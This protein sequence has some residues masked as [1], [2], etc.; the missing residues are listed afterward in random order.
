MSSIC[1]YCMAEKENYT[2]KCPMCG[3][4]PPA[5]YPPYYLPP[6]SE[7]K[8]RYLVGATIGEG[9]FG[10]TYFGLDMLTGGKVAIKEYYPSGY[11]NRTGTVSYTVYCATTGDRKDFYEKGKERFIKEAKTLAL[12][13]REDGIVKV[14]DLFTENNTAY[15]VME[16]IEGPTLKDFIAKNGKIPFN[17]VIDMLL[18]MM[19]SLKRVHDAGLIHRDIAPDNI[20]IR[21]GRG[22]LIDFGAARNMTSA[23]NRSLSVV[24]KRGFAPEE[25]YRTRGV[26][27][28]WTDIY[29]L[30]A[31]IY[32]AVTGV[33]PDDSS[34]RIRVDELKRPNEL[35]AGLSEAADAVIMKSLAV[36]QENRYKNL[37]EFID[38]LKAAENA[39]AD[40]VPVENVTAG[41][42]AAA[43]VI[44]GEGYNAADSRIDGGNETV[45][46][47]ETVFL[48][49]TPAS[50]RQYC[51][52][53]TM[54][55]N[56]TPAL[57][58]K[59]GE[60][61]TVLLDNAVNEDSKTVM[62]DE[63]A[64][65]G[66]NEGQRAVPASTGN[67]KK[68]NKG[69]VAAIILVIIL[70]ICA[71]AAGILIFGSLNSKDKRDSGGDAVVN[72]ATAA[73]TG[74][75]GDT[76]T[77]IPTNV[78]AATSTD[79]AVA[80]LTESPTATL[81]PAIEVPT[82]KP[83]ANSV[84]YSACLDRLYADDGDESQ[85]KSSATAFWM[86]KGGKLRMLG[87]VMLSDGLEKII[88]AVRA[89]SGECY[90][91]DCLGPYRDRSDV[92]DF[93]LGQG[94][95]LERGGERAGVGTDDNYA[96]FDLSA[97]PPGN[98]TIWFVAESTSGAR[99][100]IDWRWDGANSSAEW[101]M[102]IR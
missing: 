38:A 3:K 71:V 37:D 69:K 50:P 68:N 78:P 27:G 72:V 75:V 2:D 79:A 11:V 92:A 91:F 87:W 74:V 65:Y 26:Q 102:E 10:I 6:L 90:E 35:G 86:G 18:P 95:S 28:P 84:Y 33:N 53:E 42:I 63:P 66:S 77:A 44:A 14:Q 64:A 24:L 100:F 80:T 32:K 4:T 40:N 12:F 88:C 19:E 99:H 25:Q 8:G 58:Q 76:S 7:L 96:V 20:I 47:D 9:G 51:G 17:V 39:P 49:E 54:L 67:E 21:N 101:G 98:Y 13:S 56:E 85:I 1:I 97:L 94:C 70:L 59:Y 89:K 61:K 36:F 29:A 73:P 31:T 43:N 93:F 60:N 46:L 81:P 5:D 15:I 57:P 48:N 16:F 55:L 30:G 23:D 62:M 45:L 82:S 22:V 52:D 34:E 83:G 41:G